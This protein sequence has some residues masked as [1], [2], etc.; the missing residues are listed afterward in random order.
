MSVE[1]LNVA[2][3]AATAAG[4]VSLIKPLIID[5]VQWFREKFSRTRTIQI[6]L[7]VKDHN[8]VEFTVEVTL[9]EGDSQGLAES[10][11]EKLLQALNEAGEAKDGEN[12]L[13]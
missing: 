4:M 6:K 13:K 11:I 10:D 1:F 8:G 9:P 2:A 12:Q 5:L 3:L 7:S